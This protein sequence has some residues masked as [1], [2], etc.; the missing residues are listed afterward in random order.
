MPVRVFSVDSRVTDVTVRVC[1]V[2]FRV[3]DVTVRVCSVDSRVAEVPFRVCSVDSRVTG[4][5]IIYHDLLPT[6][7]RGSHI[8]SGITHTQ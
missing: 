3:T 4:F 6:P 7:M 1:S 2:D 5:T 8:K